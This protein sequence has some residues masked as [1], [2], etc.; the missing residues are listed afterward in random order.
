[1]LAFRR[2]SDGSGLDPHAGGA[3]VAEIK[4]IIRTLG[5]AGFN[6]VGWSEQKR[7]RQIVALLGAR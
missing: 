3:T 6:D 2:Q 4:A 5:S 1:L 7:T